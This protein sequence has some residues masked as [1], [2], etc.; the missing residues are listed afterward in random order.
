M[1]QTYGPASADVE[2]AFLSIANDILFECWNAFEKQKPPITV[3]PE[4]FKNIDLLVAMA[5]EYT[6][7]KIANSIMFAACRVN[8]IGYCK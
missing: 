1:S 8:A 6:S 7:K 5:S 3:Q 2:S 4:L